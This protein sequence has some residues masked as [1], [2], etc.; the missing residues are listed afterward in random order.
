MSYNWGVDTTRL[1]IN[2]K[3]HQ[4]WETEQLINFGLNGKKISRGFLKKNFNIL[5]LDPSKKDF[6]SFLIWQKLS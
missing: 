2:T 3:D 6:L 5:N 1:K 4:K